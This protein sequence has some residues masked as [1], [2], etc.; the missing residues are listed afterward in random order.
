MSVY[1]S[2]GGGGGGPVITELFEVYIDENDAS[3]NRN[4]DFN[5][6][7]NALNSGKLVYLKTKDNIDNINYYYLSHLYY[8][9]YFKFENFVLGGTSAGFHQYT[10]HDD[11]SYNHSSDYISRVDAYIDESVTPPTTTHVIFNTLKNQFNEATPED[12]I[13]VY[14][15][16]N[17]DKY[18]LPAVKLTATE[19]MFSIY[20]P[21]AARNLS[22][23]VND[24][25]QYTVIT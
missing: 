7:L 12:C 5:S 13:I 9:S 23:V 24:Q 18:K 21:D 20:D 14:T 2:R 11:N 10:I 1:N 17:G 16:S 15:K 25:N 22:I 8:E 4:V 19:I 6:I 3:N